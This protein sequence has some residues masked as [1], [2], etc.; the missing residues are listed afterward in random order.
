[1]IDA[2]TNIDNIITKK[3]TINNILY[4]SD[5]ITLR[6]HCLRFD[7]LRSVTTTIYISTYLCSKPLSITR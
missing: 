1:M 5:I 4:Y 2:S 3:I 6:A 7:F